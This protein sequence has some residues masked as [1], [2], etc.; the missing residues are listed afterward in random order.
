MQK[1]F[2]LLATLTILATTPAVAGDYVVL[3]SGGSCSGDV[4]AAEEPACDDACSEGCDDKCRRGR[5]RRQSKWGYNCT[6]NGSY[7]FP[8]PPLSTY[9]WPGMYSHRLMTDYHSPWRFPALKPYTDEE[10][11][12]D[13]QSRLPTIRPISQTVEAAPRPTKRKGGIESVS[14]KMRRYYAQ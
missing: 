3:V 13:L 2:A 5:A 10:P 1:V 8:V 14:A 7:K 12:R 4:V 11:D 9:H 6:C